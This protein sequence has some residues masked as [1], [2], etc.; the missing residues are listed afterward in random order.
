MYKRIQVGACIRARILY[1][2]RAYA[3]LNITQVRTM[4]KTF[5]LTVIPLTIYKHYKH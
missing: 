5:I 2:L 4:I 1:V 3:Y